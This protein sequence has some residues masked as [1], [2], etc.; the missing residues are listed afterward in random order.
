MYSFLLSSVLSSEENGRHCTAG[1]RCAT[2]LDYTSPEPLEVD[3]P[4]SHLWGADLNPY[5]QGET[6]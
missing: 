1:T 6:Q 4:G 3:R 2:Q 5:H